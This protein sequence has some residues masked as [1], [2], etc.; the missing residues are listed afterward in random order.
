MFHRNI[1]GIWRILIGKLLLGWKPN[2][3]AGELDVLRLSLIH[4][5]GGNVLNGSLDVEPLDDLDE[6]TG[7]ELGIA[8]DVLNIQE[9]QVAGGCLDEVAFDHLLVD[10]I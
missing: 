8:E 6:L 4:L 5:N 9:Q 2:K 10:V 7:L 3:V 1:L